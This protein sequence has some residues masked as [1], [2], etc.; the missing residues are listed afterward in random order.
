MPIKRHGTRRIPPGQI[1][2]WTGQAVEN[3]A[4]VLARGGKPESLTR[5]RGKELR[6]RVG[7]LA[8]GNDRGVKGAPDKG[9]VNHPALP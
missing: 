8:V 7:R 2:T 3:M 6:A 5:S 1:D 4:A 9:A